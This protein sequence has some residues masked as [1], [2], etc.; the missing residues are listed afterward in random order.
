[1]F[2]A[3][4]TIGLLLLA[5]GSLLALIGIVHAIRSRKPTLLL[6]GLLIALLGW[7]LLLW[8]HHANAAV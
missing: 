1:M 3:A 6:T 5:T 7:A 8:V 4:I 2:T